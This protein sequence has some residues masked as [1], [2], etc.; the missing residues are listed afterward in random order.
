MSEPS[1]YEALRTNP[2]AS[3][4]LRPGALPFIFPTGVSAAQLA[5][6]LDEL[7]GQVEI[8]GPHGAG[9]S[10][11]LAALLPAL[12]ASSRQVELIELHDGQRVLPVDRLRQLEV[13]PSGTVVAIDGY[14]QLGWWSRRRVGTLCKKRSFKLVV[15]CHETVGFPLLWEARP[16]LELA[17]QIVARLTETAPYRVPPDKIERAFEGH[18]GDLREM[19]FELYDYYERPPGT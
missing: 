10:A 1:P 14:E 9:K 16:T 4:F 15:T 7:G 11:L 12:R 6:R 19:L 8:L 13:A 18:A 17:H 2:L 3:R 5:Q